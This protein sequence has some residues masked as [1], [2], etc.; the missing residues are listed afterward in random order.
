MKHFL[1]IGGPPRSGTRFITNALNSHDD[2][3]V[4]G[5]MYPAILDASLNYFS[6]TKEIY[7]EIEKNKKNEQVGDAIWKKNRKN[8]FYQMVRA[9]QKMAVLPRGKASPI[10]GFKLPRVEKSWRKIYRAAGKYSFLYCLRPFEPHFL[11]CANRWDSK[12]EAVAEKYRE[13]ISLAMGMLS[14]DLVAFSAFSLER[15]E[16]DP[17]THLRQIADSLGLSDAP[18]WVAGV[19]PAKKANSAEKFV[20]DKRTELNDEEA[21]FMSK[22]ADLADLYDNFWAAFDKAQ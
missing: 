11:S 20:A 10:Q 21:A 17:T 8:I 3:A 1:V 16:S 2:V 22:N 18:A 19:D 12:I 4:Q 7:R 14:S 15:L 5:E 6:Q 9:G 13:S